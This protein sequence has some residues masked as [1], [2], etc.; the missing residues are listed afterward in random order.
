MKKLIKFEERYV[1]L[2]DKYTKEKLFKGDLNEFF[3]YLGAKYGQR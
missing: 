3:K 1:I 2:Y